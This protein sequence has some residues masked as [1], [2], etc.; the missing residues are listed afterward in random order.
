MSLLRLEGAVLGYPERR[1]AGPVDLEIRSGES[2]LIVGPNGGGKSTL[3]KTLLGNLP[4][5]E[6]RRIPAPGL[7]LGYVAQRGTLDPAYPFTVEELVALG[8]A[9][10]DQVV[11]AMERLD[12]LPLR[13]RPCRALSGGQK[14]RTLLA[15]TLAGRPDLVLLDE[16]AEGLDLRAQRDL[17]GMVR[18]LEETGAAVVQV[19]HLLKP[20]RRTASVLLVAGSRV[21]RG[22]AREVLRPEVLSEAFGGRMS[23]EEDGDHLHVLVEEAA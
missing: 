16:P 20:V 15:R 11:R 9:P 12:L 21:L 8:G 19:G 13:S 10:A 2:L 5:L 17:G 18:L 23:V 4:P 7:R 22:T 3:L 1:V 6:G 14:Q